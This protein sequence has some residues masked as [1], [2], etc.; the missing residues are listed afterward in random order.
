M[1][2]I[3]DA[4]DKHTARERAKRTIYAAFCILIGSGTCLSMIF[5]RV[6]PQS[7]Y[8]V[9]GIPAVAFFAIGIYNW[10]AV[11]KGRIEPMR[12]QR[13]L[14][15]VCW[16]T[17]ILAF[18]ALVVVGIDVNSQSNGTA[19]AVLHGIVGL[20]LIVIAGVFK[21]IVAV[22]EAE[23]RVREKLLSLHIDGKSS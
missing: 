8:F 19:D 5:W 23:L 10:Q 20:A 9:S 7:A 21:V 16:T 18:P 17:A 2:N 15:N 3:T 1:T 11:R 22:N 14:A 6:Y 4:L 13:F 12:D